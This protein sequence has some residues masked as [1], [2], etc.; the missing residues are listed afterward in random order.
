MKK[1]WPGEP[2]SHQWHSDQAVQITWGSHERWNFQEIFL[3]NMF[4]P[5]N[6]WCY[7]GWNSRCTELKFLSN[8]VWKFVF[9]ML[10]FHSFCRFFVGLKGYE[11][12]WHIW[13]PGSMQ[14]KSSCEI[15]HDDTWCRW[16]N[17]VRFGVLRACSLSS[18]RETFFLI[19][20]KKRVMSGTQVSENGVNG[21]R[22]TP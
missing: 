20:K 16:V 21:A 11:R 15:W 17:D 19:L 5:G 18:R 14:M 3:H 7:L 2:S 10:Q 1:R 8:A 6:H 12:S 4:L 22:S 9:A 13:Q